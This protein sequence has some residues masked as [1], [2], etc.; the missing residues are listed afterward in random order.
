[1]GRE[2]FI[3][4]TVPCDSPLPK[5]GGQELKHTGTWRQ[6]LMQLVSSDCFLIEPRTTS[7][8]VSPSIMAQALPHELFNKK[9]SYRLPCP[10]PF[11]KKYY[12][13]YVYEYQKRAPDPITDGCEPPC[14]CWELNPEPSEEK[15]V[16]LTS[17]P[18]LQ[19]VLAQ[20]QNEFSQ[21]GF[22]PLECVK[23]T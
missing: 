14:G 12:L 21:L 23:L 22:P 4:L 6:E 3:S 9:M 7:P 11:L 8:G 18:S 13:F 19:P 1:L 5:Q 10:N 16:L 17:E 2:G 20:S 15:S